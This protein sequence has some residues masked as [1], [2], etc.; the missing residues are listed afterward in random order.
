[1]DNAQFEPVNELERALAQAQEGR[2]SISVLMDAFLS[3][4]VFVL[5]D[6]DPGPS[7]RWDNSASPMVLTGSTGVP[8]L[9]VFT[10]PQRSSNW[11][12]LHPQFGFGLLTDFQWLLKG[13][14]SGVGI[15]INPGATVGLEMQPTGVADLKAKA[16]G[17]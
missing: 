5:I 13:V 11:P 10:A 4:Q 17:R 16:N 2:L 7:G 9:A 12:K 8:M 14:A 1:V 3:S 6:K 15:V